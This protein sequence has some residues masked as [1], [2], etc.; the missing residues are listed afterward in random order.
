MQ[1][2]HRNLLNIIKTS[3]GG[4]SYITKD[5]LDFD[6]IFELGKKHRIVPLVFNGLYMCYG[7]ILEVE[8]FRGHMMKSVCYDQN[9]LYCL[10][11][12]E[13]CFKAGNI[14]YMCLKGASIKKHYDSS[15]LRLMG[16]IDILIKEEQYSKIKELLTGLGLTEFRE[17][18]HEFIWRYNSVIVVELHRRLIPSYNDDYYEYYSNPW[19]KAV[20]KD[21]NSFSMTP[22]DEYI[23]IFTHLT[24]HYRDGGIGLRHIV[25]MYVF[26]LKNPS[27]DMEYI[28]RELEK[29]GLKQFYDNIIDTI[30]VWFNDKAETELTDYITE[31][32]IQS[33]EYGIKEKCDAANAAKIS[34]VN[35]S[36]RTAKVKTLFSL[37]FMPYCKM[38]K[39]YPILNKLPILLPV[40]WVIR[41]IDAIFCRRQNIKRESERLNQIDTQVVD[42][43]N[44][45]LEMVGLRFNY[46]NRKRSE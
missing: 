9:Q 42:M 10:G 35:A 22:E 19:E 18:D 28:N 41:W 25:D 44:A 37:I 43:Y 5:K 6:E 2:N 8:K 26:A 16:D 24:K 29:L 32:I 23:Y 21:G 14:D 31:R 17:T 40:M 27:L 36:V 11:I 12:I 45:E 4:S 3:L 33:G 46:K 30:D 15:E 7:G 39:R 34:A 20:I 13:E 1:N 38:K